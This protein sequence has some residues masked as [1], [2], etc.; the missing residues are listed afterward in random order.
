MAIY[1]NFYAE[2]QEEEEE[3]EKEEEEREKDF[4][5]WRDEVDLVKRLDPADGIRQMG[6]GDP[7]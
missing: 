5:E 7:V 6:R 1:N 3:D 2:E 4:D